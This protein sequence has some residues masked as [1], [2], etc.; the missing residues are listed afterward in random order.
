M[1]KRALASPFFRQRHTSMPSQGRSASLQGGAV[2][3]LHTGFEFVAFEAQGL[4]LQGL[5]LVGLAHRN[6]VV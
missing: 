6:D 5:S 4:E 2:I 3:P 1:G